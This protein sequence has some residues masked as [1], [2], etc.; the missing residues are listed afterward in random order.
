MSLS[1]WH[2]D[3]ICRKALSTKRCIETMKTSTVQ[4]PSSGRKAL[5]T[6]RCIETNAREQTDVVML[7]SES[8]EHQKVH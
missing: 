4:W 3:C 5:S 7:R 8:T 6:K 2:T 1:P